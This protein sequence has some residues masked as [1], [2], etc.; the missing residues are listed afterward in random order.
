[1]LNINVRTINELDKLFSISPCI[2]KSIRIC[3]N[4]EK[5]AKIK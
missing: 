3:S 4:I 5:Q 2:Y 1:M